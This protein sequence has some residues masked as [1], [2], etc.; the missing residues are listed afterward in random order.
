MALGDGTAWDETSPSGSSLISNGDNEIRDL[1]VGVRKRIE[2]EHVLPAGL[3]V[4]GEHKEG[5]AKVY[6]TATTP[7]LRPDGS[8]SLDTN[9]EGRLWFNTTTKILK[10]RSSTTWETIIGTQEIAQLVD[11]GPM[12]TATPGSWVKRQITD[13]INDPY[14]IVSLDSNV[15]TLGAG[16]Y[17]IKVKAF[18]G[19]VNRC[20]LRLYNVTAGCVVATGGSNYHDK[21]MSVMGWIEF[22]LIF[23]I[24]SSTEYSIQN[25]T[26]SSGGGSAFGYSMTGASGWSGI[27]MYLDMTIT[28]LSR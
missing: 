7:T 22:E 21:A 5:S 24:A 9:D 26:E 25:Y 15:F 17:H 28:R 6:A 11:Y 10:H 23:T 2:K 20:Q 18:C 14:G 8:T 19:A 13:I 4:G 12:T 16:T 3:T 27:N 1:R